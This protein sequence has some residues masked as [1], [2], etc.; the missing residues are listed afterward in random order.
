M[1][2]GVPVVPEVNAIRQVSSAAVGD[3]LELRRLG[4]RERLEP[5]AVKVLEVR[6]RRAARE[7]ERQ[8]FGQPRVAQRM[9]D[10]R[11]A[12]D[13]CELLGAQQRHAPD[14]DPARFDDAEPTCGEHRRVGAAQQ[15]AVAGHQPH[16]VDEDVSDATRLCLQLGVG[17]AY[18]LAEQAGAISPASRHLAVEQLGGAVQSGRE[19]QL[20]EVEAELGPLLAGRQMIARERVYVCA[21]RFHGQGLVD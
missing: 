14:H 11:L 6:Q 15:H 7:R 8:L 1:P 21:R 4:S 3:V 9:A 18:P 16:V 20:G 12:D 10:L 19:A 13:L 17:P 2:F 5:A